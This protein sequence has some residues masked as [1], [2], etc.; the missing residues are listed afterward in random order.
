MSVT[1]S[2]INGKISAVIAGKADVN[3]SEEMK[4]AFD[5]Q[6]PDGSQVEIEAADLEYIASSA[7]RVFLSLYKRM[8][9][10]GGSVTFLNV[11]P[12]V[13]QIFKLTGFDTFAKFE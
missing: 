1:I 9:A 13:M 6:I 7:L 10:T 12:T 11:K 3:F 2:N 4:Q 5:A 8:D